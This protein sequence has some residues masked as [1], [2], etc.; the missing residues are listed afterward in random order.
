MTS[1][2]SPGLAPLPNPAPSPFSAWAS[3][4]WPLRA[5]AKSNRQRLKLAPLRR[6]FLLA[7]SRSR[8]VRRRRQLSA[9]TIAG[10]CGRRPCVILGERTRIQASSYRGSRGTVAGAHGTIDGKRATQVPPVRAFQSRAHTAP[11]FRPIGQLDLTAT[12]VPMPIDGVRMGRHPVCQAPP[13]RRRDASVTRSNLTPR[14]SAAP[15]SALV[16]PALP[17]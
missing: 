2:R 10:C 11:L 17:V 1:I 8:R 15:S 16:S 3:L 9:C 4:V 7:A 13:V 5:G 14:L 6:G 12:P